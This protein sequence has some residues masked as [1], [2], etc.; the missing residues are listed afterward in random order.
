MTT[1]A[2]N[3][4]RLSI[5]KLLLASVF[6]FLVLGI[7]VQAAS[8]TDVSI[9]KAEKV[10]IEEN[11]VTI[12]A[13]AKTSIITLSGDYQADYKGAMFMGRPMTQITIKSDKATFIIRRPVPA[14]KGQ[15]LE[16]FWEKTLQTARDLQ[17]GKEVGRIGY[18]T[19]DVMIRKNLIVSIDGPGFLYSKGK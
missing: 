15:A 3:R 7:P 11:A 6:A 17:E 18:Y 5:M 4:L 9:I 8:D 16:Q 1:C 14:R 2:T 10:V 13:E 19:P 12:I